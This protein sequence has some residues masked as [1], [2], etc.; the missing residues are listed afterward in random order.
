MDVPLYIVFSISLILLS[1]L[2]SGFKKAFF[3]LD[4]TEVQALGGSGACP[5]FRFL[6]G[7]PQKTLMTLLILHHTLWISLII[8][9]VFFFGDPWQRGLSLFL[10][11]FAYL[12]LGRVLPRVLVQGQELRYMRSVSRSVKV[13][14][15]L[16]A[17]MRV[18]LERA[19]I[20]LLRER[21]VLDRPVIQDEDFRTIVP[22]RPRSSEVYDRE[23][24]QNVMEFR[25]TL[26]KEVMTPRPDMTCIEVQEDL[27][28]VVQKV[29]TSGFSRIPV[30]AGDLDH[31]V[32]I[33]YA[34]DLLPLILKGIAKGEQVTRHLLQPALHVPETKRVSDL[35]RDFKKQN[36]HIAMVVDEFGGV[37]GLVCLED[38]L[39]EIVGEIQDEGDKEEKMVVRVDARTYRIS[40]MLPLDEFNALFDV[41]IESEDYETIGGFV[42]DQ[43]GHFPKWGEKIA[44]N[45]LEISVNRAKGVRILELLVTEVED[46]PGGGGRREEKG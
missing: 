23:M 34:K 43:L 32:G 33:L 10:V 35:L 41:A 22:E 4:R 14:Y 3:V 28:R 7:R 11:F 17:P 6:A 15:H 27:S 24:I 9:T 21:E 19:S 20:L 39:E 2:V 18:F 40:A 42:V 1:A 8:V 13:F 44:Y 45:S 26:V 36:V 29:K 12:Y 30:Y 31:I 25:E 5:A 46:G 38:L 37:E 16:C